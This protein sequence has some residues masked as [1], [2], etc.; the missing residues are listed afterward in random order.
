MEEELDWIQLPEDLDRN[1]NKRA[2][3]EI[4]VISVGTFATAAYRVSPK[5]VC[6]DDRMNISE[7]ESTWEPESSLVPN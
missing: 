3:E 1:S 2:L 6:N 7:E 4:K 5:K